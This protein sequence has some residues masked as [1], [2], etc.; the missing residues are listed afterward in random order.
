MSLASVVGKLN[1]ASLIVGSG[2]LVSLEIFHA[3]KCE[4]NNYRLLK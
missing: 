1:I 4:L 3:E 2:I